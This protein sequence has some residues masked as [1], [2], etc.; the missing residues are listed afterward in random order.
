MP[1]RLA[2][3]DL[4][5][6][7]Q[8]FN[9]RVIIAGG[10]AL[11]L[12]LVVVARLIHLQVF[13]FE[14]FTTLSQSN[15]VRLV[16][17]PP[18]RGLIYD[19]H[20]VLLAENR[21]AYSL[22]ITPEAV[23]D[24][25]DTLE[26]LGMIV[27]LREVD[28]ERFYRALRSKRPFQT[29]PVR[30]NLSDQEVARF[31]VNRQVFAGV[32]IEARLTRY[33]PLRGGA[34]H[35]VGYVGRIDERDTQTL[36]AEAYAGSTH[37]GKS[38]VEK[39]YEDLLHGKVGYEQVE[40]NA[41][42]RTL[43]V[44]SRQDPAPGQ[45]L[46]LS[47]DAELQRIAE[48]AL[49][50]YNGAAVALDPRNGE[51]L[52][53]VS[54]PTYDPNL[55]VNGISREDY[56]ALNTDPDRPLFNRAL[57]GRY[58]PGSTIKPVIGLAGLEY[59]ATTAERTLFAPG[60]YTLPNGTRRFR[61]WK[62]EGHG[63]VDLDKSIA[64]SCDVYFYDLAYRLGIDKMYEF[65][66][67]FG[68]GEPLGID[69][70]GE[71]GGI[72][73]SREWKWRTRGQAWFPGETVIVGIGQGYLTT[74]PL[75]LASLTATLATRGLRPRPRLLRAV[76]DGTTRTT[77]PAESL[78]QEPVSLSSARYWDDVLNAMVNVMHRRG[79]TAYWSA[80]RDAGYTIAG[81]TG[82]AQVF[83]L[84][85]DEEYDEETIAEHLRD[86][87]LFIAF[88]PAEEPRIAL[89]V[90]AENGGSGSAVA[91]P[92]A[93]RILDAYLLREGPDAAAVKVNDAGG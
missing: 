57:T 87:S 3:K 47:L 50:G 16:A 66:A 24:L 21:P 19:R 91:A 59:G 93:R 63:I 46:V 75:Q 6:E 79:G 85:Q 90:V 82:T 28:I 42:G 67:R 65:M 76:F 74:T 80:G 1:R 10:L 35:A 32:D 60:Y 61:D 51:V 15:R 78:F 56:R 72:L 58:P 64:E 22:E 4:Q 86:H 49:E 73:P 68:L 40:V 26:R 69:S 41:Q 38:G 33:Y 89:A 20:G 12:M 11:L 36:D 39:H 29:I 31:A 52:A 81:K 88:A 54:V 44:L 13:S 48:Q 37:V 30:F 34:V 71:S 70:T 77:V 25:Q 9:A 45:D 53:L 8:L 23:D 2:I 84:K 55:F 7:R 27:E 62:R 83:G 17:V 43:R 5:R 18:P 14:H 92:V